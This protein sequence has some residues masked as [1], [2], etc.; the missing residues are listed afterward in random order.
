[1]KGKRT[2]NIFDPKSKE[3]YKLSRSKLENFLRCPLCFYL[4]RR[5]GVDQPPGFPFTLNVAVDH[6]LKKEFDI[7]R[8]AKTAHP[9]MEKY[10]INAVPFEHPD[11]EKWRD[12]FTGVQCH[13]KPSNFR[14]TGERRALSP[15]LR[16]RRRGWP[17]P[18]RRRSPGRSIDAEW[19]G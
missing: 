13:H 15:R 5:L 8:V 3:P 18:C 12:N 6:L 19:Q 11:M 17:P 9:L 7:H 10:G 4:D 1:M 14:L 2:R 16:R